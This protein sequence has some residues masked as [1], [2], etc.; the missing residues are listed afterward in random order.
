MKVTLNP[1]NVDDKTL[2]P[3]ITELWLARRDKLVY[4]LNRRTIWVRGNNFR[5]PIKLRT[6][7]TK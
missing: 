1:I 4:D 6:Y 5:Y 3:E 2:Y 7:A